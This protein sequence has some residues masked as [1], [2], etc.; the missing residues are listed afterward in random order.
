MK[1][2]YSSIGMD[3]ARTYSKNMEV[4]TGLFTAQDENHMSNDIYGS[5]VGNDHEEESSSSKK[6]MATVQDIYKMM[7]AGSETQIKK[8][9]QSQ[10]EITIRN[11][12]IDQLLKWLFERKSASEGCAGQDAEEMAQELEA[13][14]NSDVLYQ[15][16]FTYEYQEE[17]EAVS[18]STMG[19]VKT[20]DGKEFSF[21][22][23]LKMDRYSF[24][25][26]TSSKKVAEM[27]VG[28]DEM[29]F[30]TQNGELAEFPDQKF[31]IKLDESV[32][33]KLDGKS[34]VLA[35][36]KDGNG[37]V[38]DQSELIG[39]GEKGGFTELAEYDK[40]SNGWIDENDEIFSKLRVWSVDKDGNSTLIDLKEAGVGALYLES[41]STEFELQ[42]AKTSQ[43]QGFVSR[44]G[45]FLYENGNVGIMQQI[46]L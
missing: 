21:H 13:T 42:G 40:D 15:T 43:E 37:E 5:V 33:L 17:N 22:I 41:A 31:W 14:V 7:T 25:Y 36:D 28:P 11:Q 45:A 44:T 8:K 35:L 30:T 39:G 38:N 1:I 46:N 2:G 10:M 24:D 20:E 32:L 6:T 29:H 9:K 27:I 18:F 4:Y 26:F 19:T 23:D 12:C 3:S 34:G 16:E